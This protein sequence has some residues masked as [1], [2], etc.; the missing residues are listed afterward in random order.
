MISLLSNSSAEVRCYAARAILLV[1]KSQGINIVLS[2]IE[3][4]ET[5]VRWD[6]CGLM[7][8]FG[9]EQAIDPL[10]ER[11]KSDP[12]PQV[13]ATAAYALGGIGS[14]LAISALQETARDDHEVDMHNFSPSDCAKVALHNIE[15]KQRS[16]KKSSG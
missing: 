1:E 2:L 16:A 14:P 9:D 6:I 13:R 8:D 7:H 15:D 11:M 5:I 4:E 10:I 3:D 12:D